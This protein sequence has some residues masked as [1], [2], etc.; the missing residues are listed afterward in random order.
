MLGHMLFIGPGSGPRPA[1]RGTDAHRTDEDVLL[2]MKGAER[3]SIRWPWTC[4][5]GFTTSAFEGGSLGKESGGPGKADH[6]TRRELN[7]DHK[8]SIMRTGKDAKIY[9]IV[10][11][12][13]HERDQFTHGVS[14][15]KST[16]RRVGG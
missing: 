10:T 7:P 16:R 2:T 8:L 9:S 4:F 12:R 1:R 14:F 5:V 3:K 6:W 11:D 15:P 13:E